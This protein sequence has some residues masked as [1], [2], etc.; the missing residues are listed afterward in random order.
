MYKSS[1]LK[2]IS[3]SETLSADRLRRVQGLTRY[4][5]ESS[6]TSSHD[7]S[8]LFIGDPLLV[9][10]QNEGPFLANIVEMKKANH[11]LTEFD[12]SKGLNGIDLTL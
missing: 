1:C 2:T 4:P 12:V 8:L 11:V 5:G 7:D 3:S 10:K 6:V 9:S